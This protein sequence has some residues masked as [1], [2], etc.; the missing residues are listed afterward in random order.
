MKVN[1][2]KGTKLHN[3]DYLIVLEQD[4][5]IT[6]SRKPDAKVPPPEEPMVWSWE[7]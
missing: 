5:T 3:R 1:L 7:K 2:P 4:T 6:I